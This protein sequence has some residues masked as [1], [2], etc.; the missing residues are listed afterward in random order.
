MRVPISTALLLAMSIACA[1]SRAQ[2]E[3]TDAG[4]RSQTGDAAEAAA[5]NEGGETDKD[6]RPPFKYVGKSFSNKFHRPSCPF[7][8]CMSSNHLVFFEHRH[9][10]TDRGFK[11]CKY[12]LPANWKTVHAVILPISKSLPVS[13]VSKTENSTTDGNETSATDRGQQSQTE[14]RL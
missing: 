3:K 4:A 13:E 14:A 2:E 11:P 10:A 12:C 7:A 9:D 6:G 1:P 8:Q 5:K